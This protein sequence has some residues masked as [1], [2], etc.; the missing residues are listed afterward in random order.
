VRQIHFIES[1]SRDLRSSWVGFF[2]VAKF[3]RDGLAEVSLSHGRQFMPWQCY[4]E[5]SRALKQTVK[6]ELALIY[7]QIM[8]RQTFLYNLKVQKHTHIC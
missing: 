8:F 5:P 6:G 2:A 1:C 7:M 4:A 3:T